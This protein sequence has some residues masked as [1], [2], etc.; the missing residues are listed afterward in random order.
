MTCI[1]IA[2]AIQVTLDSIRADS[3]RLVT[4]PSDRYANGRTGKASGSFFSLEKKEPN[5]TYRNRLVCP[6]EA[7]TRPRLPTTLKHSEPTLRNSQI[8]SLFSYRK[9]KGYI[10]WKGGDNHGPTHNATPLSAF[11]TNGS[12]KYSRDL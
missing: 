3:K 6:R 9:Q 11:G 8:F 2:V 5:L 12:R 10:H 1:S 7:P 4:R